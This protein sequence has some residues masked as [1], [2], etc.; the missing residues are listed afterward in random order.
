GRRIYDNIRK[1]MSY[2]VAVHVPTAGMSLL[3]LLLDWPLLFYPV[4]IVFLEFVIDPASS[5]AFEA[6]PAERSVMSR[7][8][9][10]ASS[11]LF[12]APTMIGALLQGVGIL[13]VVATL[14]GAAL[15]HGTP[16]RAARAMAFTGMVLGNLGMILV[17]RSRDAT[18]RETLR[19]PNPATWWVVGGTLAGLALALYVPPLRDIFRFDAPGPLQILACAAAAAVGIAWLQF[20]NRLRWH[21]HA[22]ASPRTPLRGREG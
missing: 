21:N 10:T 3:P 12:D 1:A 13:L 14:Y 22:D 4:H 11:R 8:P 5:I 7:P 9:R 2:I 15:A 20:T 18:L 17:N 19:R 16:E 6:E